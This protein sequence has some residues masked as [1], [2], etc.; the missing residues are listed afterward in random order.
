MY[1]IILQLNKGENQFE[2][3]FTDSAYKFLLVKSNSLSGGKI[4]L[5]F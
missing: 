4:L 2:M 5:D 1:P 3:P